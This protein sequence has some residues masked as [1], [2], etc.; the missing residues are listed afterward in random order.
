MENNVFHIPFVRQPFNMLERFAPNRVA[1]LLRGIGRF[2]LDENN[3]AIGNFF[4]GLQIRDFREGFRVSFPTKVS[5][6]ETQKFH[7]D[8]FINSSLKSFAGLS[9]LPRQVSIPDETEHLRPAFFYV[10]PP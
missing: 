3:Y 1:M 10:A 7:D 4:L 5:G 8:P 9:C 6:L 2:G